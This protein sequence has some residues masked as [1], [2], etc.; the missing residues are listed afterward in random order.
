MELT[1]RIISER[2]HPNY[3]SLTAPPVLELIVRTPHGKLKLRRTSHSKPYCFIRKRDFT[4]NVEQAIRFIM[5]R[6]HDKQMTDKAKVVWPAE[7]LFVPLYKHEAIVFG[8]KEDEVVQIFTNDKQQVKLIRDYLAHREQKEDSK[9][10]GGV[11]KF[12][13]EEYDLDWAKHKELLG[14]L[15]PELLEADITFTRRWKIDTGVFNK[16]RITDDAFL[17]YDGKV[18]APEVG[19]WDIETNDSRGKPKAGIDEVRAVAISKKDREWVF[20]EDQEADTISVSKSVLEKYCDIVIGWGSEKFDVDVLTK[21]AANLSKGENPLLKADPFF[22]H[23]FQLIDLLQVLYDEGKIEGYVFD[24]YR[25]ERVVQEV[26]VKHGFYPKTIERPGHYE[27]LFQKDRP[28]LKEINLS[29]ARAVRDLDKILGFTDLKIELADLAG[30]EIRDTEYTNRMVDTIIM[31][32]ICNQRPRLVVECRKTED[33]IAEE[34]SYGGGMCF[35]PIPGLFHNI[36]HFDLVSMYVRIIQAFNISP[37][38]WWQAKEAGLTKPE[39]LNLED[40]TDPNV[41]EYFDRLARFFAKLPIGVFPTEIAETN[42]VRQRIKDEM[43]EFKSKFGTESVEYKRSKAQYQAIK[44][45]LNAFYG[46]IGSPTSRFYQH[47]LAGFIPWAGR[48]VIIKAKNAIE[49]QFGGKGV[50]VLYGDT[51]SL[52]VDGPEELGEEIKNFINTEIFPA[53][54]EFRWDIAPERR[55]AEIGFEEIDAD[56]YFTEAKK[57]YFYRI[58]DTRT[59]KTIPKIEVVGLETIRADACPIAREV[60]EKMLN[61][62]LDGESRE[63]M[64]AYLKNVK[65]QVLN[66]EIAKEKFV[67]ARGMRRDASTYKNPPLFVKAYQKMEKDGVALEGKVNFVVSKA[68]KTKVLDVDYVTGFENIPEMDTGALAYYWTHYV[69]PPADRVID[70]KKDEFDELKFVPLYMTDNLESKKMSD[71]FKV[72]CS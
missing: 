2:A 60:Q 41:T 62:V 46:L 17:P 16:V 49:Q 37:E 23:K 11:Y 35:P 33:Y 69:L 22:F 5:E 18:P 61:A 27:E 7:P 47:E 43:T 28:R 4:P 36:L 63:K 67:M 25:L 39:G 54:Y 12:N 6:H 24:S 71:Y 3:Q 59:G 34:G 1:G 72:E 32:R 68:S 10:R 26:L 50:R 70:L 56:I 30:I 29:H 44:G 57:R 42:K 64:K 51:D 8:S 9:F 53:L 13:S 38:L 45:I 19:Y 15:K 14:S 21:R 66:G 48:E 65:T 20:S 52:F 58:R 55:L 40:V 31:R